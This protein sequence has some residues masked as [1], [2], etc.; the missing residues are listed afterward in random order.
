MSAAMCLIKNFIKQYEAEQVKSS[1]SVPELQ[2]DKDGIP[3]EEAE[4]FLPLEALDLAVSHLLYV[5]KNNSHGFLDMAPTPDETPSNFK[6]KQ[7]L[8]YSY[9]VT[10]K[11]FRFSS[12]PRPRYHQ[13]Q[14]ILKEVIA[15]ELTQETIEGSTNT[16]I[17]KPGAKS[18]GRGIVPQNSFDECI[19]L[20]DSSKEEKWVVQKYIEHP[21]LV[22][23][24]KFDI[25]QWFMVTDWNP[26][27]LYFYQDSYLRFGSKPFTMSDFDPCIHLCNNSIQKKY[28][29]GSHGTT[30]T[31]FA[32]G[33]MWTN[34][35][36]KKFLVK[37]GKPTVWDEIIYPGMKKS[38]QRVMMTIQDVIEDRKNSFELYGA[39]FMI[40]E[41]YIP[42]LIEINC[43]PA[44]GGTT[45]ITERLCSDVLDDCVKVIIDK[46]ENKNAP[47]GKWEVI[48]KQQIITVPPYIGVQLA[49]EGKY[50]SKP[51][52]PRRKK[53]SDADSDSKKSPK[54]TK[55]LVEL[56]P[57]K[58]SNKLEHKTSKIYGVCIGNEGFHPANVQCSDKA[59]TSL[60]CKQAEKY[61]KEL[62]KSLSL[63]P[64]A[65]TKLFGDPFVP[66]CAHQHN[67][68]PNIHNGIRGDKPHTL[69][70]QQH[71]AAHRPP[72]SPPAL[73]PHSVSHPQ[74]TIG[75]ITGP[76]PPQQQTLPSI[77]MSDLR[78]PNSPGHHCSLSISPISSIPTE[79]KWIIKKI[80][81]NGRVS[82]L[83]PTNINPYRL[84]QIM[85]KQGRPKQL[86][87]L[88]LQNK[89]S[90]GHNVNGVKILDIKT[91]KR[92]VRKINKIKSLTKL[93]S[94]P[95]CDPNNPKGII[96]NLL[97]D[98][99]NQV[100]T[101]VS[102]KKEA[103]NPR[104]KKHFRVSL[105]QVAQMSHKVVDIRKSG[106]HLKVVGEQP[107]N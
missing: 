30:D 64:P 2:L 33:N 80:H 1:K 59:C 35:A 75:I 41:H 18:R 22:H 78:A 32:Q 44:M 49:L 13:A 14:E 98:P 10:A 68:N 12:Y 46:K 21:L 83:V 100:S 65:S 87:M 47:T 53:D 82:D 99:S 3:I 94:C 86:D 42:W 8:N 96:L 95:H 77:I 31:T 107:S 6:R 45:K 105:S 20:A 9:K 67:P 16:W 76:S 5:L 4:N 81:K 17:M 73:H 56:P 28:I 39:D 48:Y 52:P 26:L 15:L 40:D 38:I 61:Q 101:S 93:T 102:S 60:I 57:R 88:T 103:S 7:L 19:K 50:L 27:T 69:R 51:S 79:D 29:N 34:Q 55:P 89:Y 106:S 84:Q 85:G 90:H 70:E 36:F 104:P 11:N 24:T 63:N 43:S 71:A 58:A 66:N 91:K 37:K 74:S 72:S 23:N 25:R 54:L 97:K 92:K 62:I